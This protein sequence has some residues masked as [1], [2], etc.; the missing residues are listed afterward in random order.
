MQRDLP[1]WLKH[2]TVWSVL[3]VGIFLGVRAWQSH[4]EATRLV[5][6]GSTIEIRRSPDGHY[7]WLGTV[8]GRPVEFLVDTGATATALPAGLA[9][10]LG[11]PVVGSVQS[12]TAGG[13]VQGTV[14]VGD[15]TLEGGVA[16]QRLRI[17]V[18][19]GLSKP[20]LG[21]DVLGRLRLQQSQGVLR[22]DLQ[23]TGR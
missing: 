22:I 15:L 9:R 21:M 11:L 20:L 8:A 19:P 1:P 6:S 18:L 17:T 7:H 4:Q 16:A 23:S 5:V 3:A 13:V 14:V 10:E 2:A 12:S